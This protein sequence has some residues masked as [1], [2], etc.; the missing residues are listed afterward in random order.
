MS[1]CL[2]GRGQER[3]CQDFGIFVALKCSATANALFSLPGSVQLSSLLPCSSWPFSRLCPALCFSSLLYFKTVLFHE[4]SC[5]FCFSTFLEH[6]HRT[7]LL[8]GPVILLHRYQMAIISFNL[9]IPSLSSALNCFFF[10]YFLRNCFVMFFSCVICPFILSESTLIVTFSFPFLPFFSLSSFLFRFVNS[11]FFSC[12]IWLIFCAVQA[13]PGL[14]RFNL[15]PTCSYEQT[16][17]AY[18]I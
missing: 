1:Q 2:K 8:F 16:L 13:V 7:E 5:L 17:K 6:F 15:R 18:Y 14:R 9:F 3:E 12:L 4:S 10:P 11:V